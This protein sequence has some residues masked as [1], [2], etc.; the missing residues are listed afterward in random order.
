MA[1][2]IF[3]WLYLLVYDAEKS[4]FHLLCLWP[5]LH[6]GLES[7]CWARVGH[8]TIV[9]PFS[10]KG[11]IYHG[12]LLTY[13]HTCIGGI[14]RTTRVCLDTTGRHYADSARSSP[15]LAKRNQKKPMIC[16]SAARRRSALGDSIFFKSKYAGG[17]LSSRQPIR[18]LAEG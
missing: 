11:S 10:L 17:Q 9:F 13:I 7:F 14:D 12:P 8:T 5:A 1:P 15:P 4:P 18:G 2:R 16:L 3:N 6:L